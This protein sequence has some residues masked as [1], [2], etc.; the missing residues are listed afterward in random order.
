MRRSTRACGS[1][2]SS[3]KACASTASPRAATARS[4]V[5]GAAGAGRPAGGVLRGRYPHEFSGGQ[6]QRIGIA[7]ALAVNPK[8]IVADEPVSALD[9]SIQAQILN[10]LLDLQQRARPD[11]SVHLARSA[12]GRAHQRP[13]RGDVSRQDR[14]DRAGREASPAGAAS[15]HAGAA[16]RRAGARSGA[17]GASASCCK[18]TCRARSIRQAA[19]VSIRAVRSRKSAVPRKSRRLNSTAHMA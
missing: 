10:L 17:Q 9:V 14:R 6:R 7:R 4:R 12:R 2:R 1:A 16:L 13:R 8:F 18:A 15:L 5:H 11:L 19:A 3:A